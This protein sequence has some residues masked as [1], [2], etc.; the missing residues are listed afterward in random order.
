[1]YSFFTKF[2]RVDLVQ[3]IDQLTRIVVQLSLS[4]RPKTRNVVALVYA[5]RKSE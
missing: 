5:S 4:L 1:V 2:G 3:A